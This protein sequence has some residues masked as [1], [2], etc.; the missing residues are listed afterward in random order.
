MKWLL[1]PTLN[2][3][4]IPVALNNSGLAAEKTA[5]GPTYEKML[6][7]LGAFPVTKL[8]KPYWTNGNP[9]KVY[10][11]GQRVDVD[12]WLPPQCIRAT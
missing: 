11:K 10:S 4:V 9:G 2:V 7:D 3:L 1:F 6:Y 12:G 5:T 8:T